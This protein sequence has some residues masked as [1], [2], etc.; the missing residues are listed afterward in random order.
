MYPVINSSSLHVS[1]EGVDKVQVIVYGNLVRLRAAW[2]L[3]L[4]AVQG[5]RFDSHKHLTNG[6]C[7][8]KTDAGCF[9]ENEAA[10]LDPRYRPYPPKERWFP[11]VGWLGLFQ[12]Q[13]C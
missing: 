11:T 3:P 1:V 7:T 6:T 2:T 12:P 10:S 9:L 5:E 4:W 13:H 8:S